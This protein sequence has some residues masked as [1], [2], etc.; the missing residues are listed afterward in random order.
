M[1][2]TLSDL[3]ID[4]QARA[5]GT[6]LPA[7]RAAAVR[8][9]ADE[10]GVDADPGWLLPLLTAAHDGRE[11]PRPVFFDYD[12]SDRQTYLFELAT[13]LGW[14]I[15][16]AGEYTEIDLPGWRLYVSNEAHSPTTGRGGSS[17][18]VTRL[19]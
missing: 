11:V 4:L 12:D 17:Y 2:M 16:S 7:E 19:P 6:P 9:L 1:T 13:L 15:D 3:V 18:T 5:S 14:K 8:D 10:Y